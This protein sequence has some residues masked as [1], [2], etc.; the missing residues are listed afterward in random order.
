M[1][2]AGRASWSILER[3]SRFD[4]IFPQKGEYL[5]GVIAPGTGDFIRKRCLHAP[6]GCHAW[7]IK[8]PGK[9]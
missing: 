7:E 2:L 6:R 3:R 9:K 1:N 8:D 5:G 4:A